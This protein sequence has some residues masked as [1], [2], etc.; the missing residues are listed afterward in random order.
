MALIFAEK[1]QELRELFKSNFPHI[2]V[3]DDAFAYPDAVIVSCSNPKF[4]MGAGL[5]AEIAKRYELATEIIQS[6]AEKYPLMVLPGFTARIGNVLFS[7]TVGDDLKASIRGITDVLIA[8]KIL[9]KKELVVMTGL[10]TGIGGLPHEEFIEL[11]KASG[12]CEKL[13]GGN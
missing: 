6:Y 8:V 12:L 9:A 2:E 4:T 5:D 3:V 10:G 13:Q 7:V 1:N 11:C